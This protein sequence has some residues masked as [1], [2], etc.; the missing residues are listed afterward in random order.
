MNIK[1]KLSTILAIQRDLKKLRTDGTEPDFSLGLLDVQQSSEI[2]GLNDTV[3]VR[4]GNRQY[5]L[6]LSN[7]AGHPVWKFFG[8]LYSPSVLYWFSKCDP[9]V[10]FIKV[11][12]GEGTTPS[13][14]RFTFSSNRPDT[15]PLPDP[16]FFMKRGFHELDA[17][18]EQDKTSWFDRSDDIVWRGS[19]TGTGQ[20]Y[21]DDLFADNP[22]IR[23]RIRLAYLTRGSDVDFKFSP[24]RFFQ[25]FEFRM[26]QQGVTG[27]SLPEESWVTRKY[28]I[29]I[30]GNVNT[31]SNFL[32]RLKL[33]CCVLKVDSEMRYRQWYYDHIKPW[34]HYVPVKAD[35]SDFFERVEWARANP[36]EA[37]AIAQN[38]Q[39]FARQMTFAKGREDAVALI[40]GAATRASA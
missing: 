13:E 5:Q 24:N 17:L 26:Q 16:H 39:E 2:K 37:F 32:V 25:H 38:G 14:A 9:S 27:E 30:D 12:F 35:L 19:A 7:Y 15:I 8:R 22:L 36:N 20:M 11:D 10:Q 31:W 29:D 6:L 28:A 33:G 3:I 40:E 34:E 4:R 23:Q 1:D 21:F 18:A